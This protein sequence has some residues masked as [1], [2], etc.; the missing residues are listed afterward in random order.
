MKNFRSLHLIAAT[1]LSW[2]FAASA[3]TH[4]SWLARPTGEVQCEKN[5]G[6][7]L[8]EAVAEL[9]SR[10]SAEVMQALRGKIDG[11]TQCMACGCPSGNQIFVL[12][13]SRGSLDANAS[14]RAIDPSLILADEGNYNVLPVVDLE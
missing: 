6:V 7:R 11:A 1:L 3:S 10:G 9:E 4:Y 13:R 8:S 14:W 2:S 12:V 5:S